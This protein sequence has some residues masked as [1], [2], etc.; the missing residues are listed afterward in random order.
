MGENT[1]EDYLKELKRIKRKYTTSINRMGEKGDQELKERRTVGKETISYA[2]EVYKIFYDCFRK[3][4]EVNL[5]FSKE[6][7]LM[8][9]PYEGPKDQHIWMIIYT[10]KKLSALAENIDPQEARITERDIF[11]KHKIQKFQMYLRERSV[12]KKKEPKQIIGRGLLPN[13]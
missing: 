2:E 12:K 1:M 4:W 13:N 10:I 5:E 11:M 3:L 8:R 7:D 6:R 9:S